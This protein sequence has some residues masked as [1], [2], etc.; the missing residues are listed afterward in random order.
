MGGLSARRPSGAPDAPA[1][2]S[3]NDE[4][5]LELVDVPAAVVCANCGSPDCQ[6]CSPDDNQA[7][8]VI[9]IVP[10]ERPGQRLPA[11]L[12]ST[13]RLATTSSE[14][15]FGALPEGDIIPAVRFAILAELLA[16]S[17]LVLFFAPLVFLVA[18]WLAR[19]LVLDSS[20]REATLRALASGIPGVAFAMVAIHA[21]HGLGLDWGAR[22]YGAR[23][24][25][26]RGLRFGLYA[27]GWDLLTLPLALLFLSIAEGPRKALQTAALGLSVPS[28]A[29]RAYV[30]GVYHL[31][32]TETRAACRFAV[33]LAGAVIAISVL[34][35]VLAMLFL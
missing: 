31:N 29:A 1:P 10:W 26:G 23:S 13:A 15:F 9:A 2:D 18:P 14:S 17:G 30:R 11:R 25:R 20:L 27:C 19:A 34:A 35:V 4:T 5:A 21:A 8:G 3:R 32:E 24:R 16:V 28:R 22:R 7:S 33:W 6:G 12:L